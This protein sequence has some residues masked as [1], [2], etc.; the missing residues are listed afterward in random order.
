MD[1]CRYKDL[2]RE[3]FGK[4][5]NYFLK[6]R[7]ENLTNKF[8]GE[9]FLNHNHKERFLE[10]AKDI[11]HGTIFKSDKE[12]EWIC[13]NCGYIYEGKEAPMKCPLCKYPR[14]Y[15]KKLDKKDCK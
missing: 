14:S 7:L 6:E 8:K 9:I 11:K 5:N 13:L 10:L 1:R 3:C 15:F 4:I 2:V 12:E